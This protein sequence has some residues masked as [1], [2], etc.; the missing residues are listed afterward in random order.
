MAKKGQFLPMKDRLMGFVYPEAITGCWIFHG[1]L[2]KDGYGLLRNRTGIGGD[3]KAHRVSWQEHKGSIPAGM[4]VAHDCDNRC[5]VNPSH[6]YIAT[7]KQNINDRTTRKREP[8]GEECSWAKLSSDVVAGIRNGS[9]GK[10]DVV[11]SRSQYYRIKKREC[12]KDG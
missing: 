4:E 9:L 7:H 11:V 6:L 2:D 8:R 5:C 1:K 12:W 10:S 3:F